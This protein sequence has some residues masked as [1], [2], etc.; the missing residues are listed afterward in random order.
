MS[1]EQA[2]IDLESAVKDYFKSVVGACPFC[3]LKQ[4]TQCECDRIEGIEKKAEQEIIALMKST[5]AAT[6]ASIPGVS[7]SSK[8]TVWEALPPV[9]AWASTAVKNAVGSG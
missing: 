2:L 7:F 4:N 8:S 1:S 5:N 9:R 3:D 6:H